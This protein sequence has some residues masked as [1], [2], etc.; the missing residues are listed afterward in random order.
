MN[1]NN[2]YALMHYIL[3]YTSLR[4]TD[5]EIGG[6]IFTAVYLQTTGQH[7]TAV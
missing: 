1:E 4:Q 3:V 2:I 5:I 7:N 6:F